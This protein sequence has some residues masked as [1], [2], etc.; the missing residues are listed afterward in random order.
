MLFQIF[1]LF[2]EPNGMHN[3]INFGQT[4]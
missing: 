3:E 4:N 1:Y 2:K